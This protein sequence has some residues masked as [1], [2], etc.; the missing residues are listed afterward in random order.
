LKRASCSTYI[1]NPI[2]PFPNRSGLY[3]KQSPN[4]KSSSRKRKS[5]FSKKKKY[6]AEVKNPCKELTKFINDVKS[7]SPRYL[8]YKANSK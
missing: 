2:G 4:K 8:N 1:A 3:S 7:L 5:D 6:E